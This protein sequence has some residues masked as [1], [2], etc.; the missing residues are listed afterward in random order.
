MDN[1]TKDQNIWKTYPEFDFIEVNKIGEV[2]TI[3]RTVIRSDGQKQFVRGHILKQY[4][5]HY[6]YMYV[7]FRSNGKLV[8]LKV[9]R[10]VAICFIPNLNNY[11]EV[12]HI[13]NDPTNNRWDNL[14]WCTREYNF[15]YKE[16]YGKSAAEVFGR[17]IIAVNPETSEV[18]WFKTQSE[19]GREL[20]IPEP[21]VNMTVKG[22]QKTAHDW[23]F[24]Y[25]DENAVEVARKEFG[26]KVAR[27]VEELMKQNQN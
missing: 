17:S 26:D 14:E 10:I 21:N 12:N 3:D 23:W 19:A 4:R 5:D 8:H 27:K 13:D 2:R 15:A 9:H 18:L 7:T 6:G 25:A 11:P 22:K 16:K 20:G 1:E 24:C